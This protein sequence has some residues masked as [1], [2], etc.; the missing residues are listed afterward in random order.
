MD[1]IA[2]VSF[3]VLAFVGAPRVDSAPAAVKAASAIPTCWKTDNASLD[4]KDGVYMIKYTTQGHTATEFGQLLGQLNGV[5]M[6]REAVGSALDGAIIEID[7]QAPLASGWRA[8]M[9]YPTFAALKQDA[10]AS[11]NPVLKFSGVQIS[12]ANEVRPTHH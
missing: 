9:A 8:S 10:M 2:F 6:Q 4:I 7:L 3:T 5:H 12:C 11:L 1:R